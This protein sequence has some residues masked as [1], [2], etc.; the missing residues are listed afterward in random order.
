MAKLVRRG[1]RILKM[2]MGEAIKDSLGAEL[3]VW[4]LMASANTIMDFMLHDTDP[5]Y[6]AFRHQGCEVGALDYVRERCKVLG[7]PYAICK[8]SHENHLVLSEITI[9]NLHHFYE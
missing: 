5:I 9:E 7:K 1:S 3:R 6:I 8:L 2:I 4:D